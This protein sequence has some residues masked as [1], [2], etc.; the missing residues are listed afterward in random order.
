M[1][2]LGPDSPSTGG[3]FYGSGPELLKKVY[4]KPL[5]VDSRWRAISSL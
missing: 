3:A 2:A 4:F 5:R 1:A